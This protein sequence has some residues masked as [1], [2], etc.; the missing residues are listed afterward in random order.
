[1][2]LFEAFAAE[3]ALFEPFAAEMAVAPR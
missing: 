2:T 1:M 3:M